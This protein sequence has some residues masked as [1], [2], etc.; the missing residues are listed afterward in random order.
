MDLPVSKIMKSYNRRGGGALSED[1][2][3]HTLKRYNF[4][5]EH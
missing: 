5:G 3:K 2:N 1:H 4:S